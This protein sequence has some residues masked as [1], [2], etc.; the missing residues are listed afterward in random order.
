MFNIDKQG[1]TS[2]IAIALLP[3]FDKDD[4]KDRVSQIEYYFRLVLDM[5][6]GVLNGKTRII[7]DAIE[8]QL[9]RFQDDINIPNLRETV[10]YLVVDMK[11]QFMKSGFDGRLKY[12]IYERKMGLHSI[13]GIGMDLDLTLEVMSNQEP[14]QENVQDAISDQP[15]IEQLAEAFTWRVD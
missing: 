12:K 8:L 10:R 5:A 4:G 14:E 13:Y 15:T 9:D 6:V 7:D 3:K 11:T 2:S 1:I